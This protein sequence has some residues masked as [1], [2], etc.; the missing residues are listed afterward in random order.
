MSSADYQH[1]FD[2]YVQQGYTLAWVSGYSQG[3]QA[4]YAAIWQKLT[5]APAWQ[6]KHGM[7]GAEYQQYFNQVTAAGYTLSLVCGYGVGNQAYYA[8][9]FRKIPNPPAW[10]SHNGMTSDQYQQTFNQLVGQGYSLK[11]VSG[12]TVAGQNQFAAIW[13]K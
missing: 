9:I 1:A 4:F 6:A 7:T 8:A 13:T 10:I 11:L 12:Y 5:G 3:G 2:G